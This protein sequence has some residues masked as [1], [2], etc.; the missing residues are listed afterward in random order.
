MNREEKYLLNNKINNCLTNPHEK[1]LT[2]R[3]YV[4]DVLEMYLKQTRADLLEMTTF[5]LS[6]WMEALMEGDDILN[7]HCKE[8]KTPIGEGHKENCLIG[9]KIKK[10]E[11]I[12]KELSC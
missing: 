9:V 1:D 2:K 12:I 10:A 3:L 8:C 6:D 5:L 11:Q 7:I 4:S